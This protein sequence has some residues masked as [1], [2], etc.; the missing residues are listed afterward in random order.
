[1]EIIPRAKLAFVRKSEKGYT[2][3]L[4]DPDERTVEVEKVLIS[5]RKPNTQ[6]MG[7]DQVEVSLNE[8]GGIQVNDKLETTAKGIYAIG[9]VTGGWFLS[10]AAS[11]MAVVAAE[12]A[13]GAAKTFPQPSDTK[14]NMV[15]SPGGIGGSFG[16]G[17]G[18]SGP[19]CGGG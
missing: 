18:R 15:H 13:M 16:R 3:I 9:D 8:E 10:H 11:S 17:C 5:G 19:R 1:M 14:G 6:H 7:L 12:N 4:D 2:C